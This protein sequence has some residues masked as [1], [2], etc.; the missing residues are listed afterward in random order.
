[1]LC[2][3][4]SGLTPRQSQSLV[5]SVKPGGADTNLL[6]AQGSGHADNDMEQQ[7]ACVTGFYSRPT[8]CLIDHSHEQR[9]GHEQRYSHERF[10]RS[11][12]GSL[13]LLARPRPRQS[14]SLVYSVKPGAV[15]EP[16]HRG[17]GPHPSN[18]LRAEALQVVLGAV[19]GAPHGAQHHCVK[20][21]LQPCELQ[22]ALGELVQGHTQQAV[23]VEL[24]QLGQ[25]KQQGPSQAC[26][27]DNPTSTAEWFK[28]LST[29]NSGALRNTT[30]PRAGE[31]ES[32]MFAFTSR[33]K[34]EADVKAG[35]FLEHGEYDGNLYGTK[36]AAI[37]EVVEAGRICI[38]DTSRMQMRPAS[39]TSWMAAVLVPYRLPSYSPC[40]RKRP[41]FTSASILLRLVN[42]N[43][44]LSRSPAR[45]FLEK[46][47]LQSPPPHA[48]R[49]NQNQSLPL[50][51]AIVPNFNFPTVYPRV[52]CWTHYLFDDVAHVQ[53]PLLVDHPASLLETH[54]SVASQE[55]ETPPTSPCDCVDHDPPGEG[56]HTT[57][58][59]PPPP[60]A[61][62]MVGI[63]KVAG[64]H[65]W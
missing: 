33:S 16:L 44:R 62:R 32:R 64:E 24:A 40:S 39:T 56:G 13:M 37:H 45:G 15:V 12:A 25:S 49:T 2:Q 47:I 48:L 55:C 27:R 22:L 51:G 29:W 34:M 4:R 8:T 5:Y 57:N 58:S 19:H 63:R 50:E 53:Q 10:L 52:A 23:G 14:H 35:R 1:M 41:A 17:L 54:D 3:G 6:L 11:M 46:L 18:C 42:A 21:L 65:L 38:L 61:I 36:T 28:A 26:L 43:M 31:R 59:L 7:L 9:Y 60:E 30:K 20:V